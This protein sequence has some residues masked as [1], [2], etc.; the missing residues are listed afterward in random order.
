MEAAGLAR[1]ARHPSKRDEFLLCLYKK[2]SSRLPG[3]LFCYRFDSKLK[4]ACGGIFELSSRQLGWPACECLYI[5]RNFHPGKRYL[6]SFKQ[7]L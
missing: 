2:I 5:W 3:L 1:I 6:A 4:I 7:D